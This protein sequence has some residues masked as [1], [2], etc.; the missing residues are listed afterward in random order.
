MAVVYTVSAG[1]KHT[2]YS[3]E[4]DARE[5]IHCQRLFYF[6]Q[7]VEM[8]FQN[9]KNLFQYLFSGFRREAEEN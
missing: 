8:R 3:S 7:S 5:M 6:Q 9:Q 4:F 1:A 2:V